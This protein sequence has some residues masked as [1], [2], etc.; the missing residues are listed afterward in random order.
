MIHVNDLTRSEANQPNICM[1]MHM[2][3]FCVYRPYKESITKEMN[4]DI[5][6]DLTLHLHDQMSGWLRY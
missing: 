1:V 2:Q 3:I 5:A 4:N 6:I